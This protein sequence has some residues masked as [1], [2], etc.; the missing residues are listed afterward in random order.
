MNSCLPRCQS[1]E[2]H[3]NTDTLIYMIHSYI[4]IHDA[5]AHMHATHTGVMP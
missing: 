1:S 4:V 2:G 5:C 3:T